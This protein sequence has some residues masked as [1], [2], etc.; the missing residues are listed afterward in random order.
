[1]RDYSPGD[2]M[3][4][5]HW[6]ASARRNSLQ[7]KVLEPTTTIEAA[8]FLSIDSYLDEGVKEDQYEYGISTAAS[9]ARYLM[10]KG[11]PVGLFV[12]S[13]LADSNQAAKVHPGDTP[14]Q[15]VNILESLAKV[16][17]C[18][19]VPFEQF[20]IEECR[21]LPWGT[22][23]IIVLFNLPDSLKL[24]LARL[25]DAGYRIMVY[26]TGVPRVNSDSSLFD[27]GVDQ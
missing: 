6:K 24:S 9:L 10:E 15:L 14:H 13:R 2:S 3:K 21:S 17:R 16:K 1:V 4:K 20:L 25:K 19:T 18:I 8:I 12:N 27:S 5:I 26:P 11:N 7:V 23:I 22:T